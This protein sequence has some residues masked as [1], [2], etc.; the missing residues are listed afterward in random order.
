[1]YESR[2]GAGKLFAA[3]AAQ[4]P[5][6]QREGEAAIA[7]ALAVLACLLAAACVT[8]EVAP[9]D[10]VGDLAPTGTLRAA[11]GDDGVSAAL[12]RELAKRLGVPVKLVTPREASDVAFLR[13]ERQGGREA[14]FV[15]ATPPG[16]PLGERYLREFLDEMKA[17]GFIAAQSEKNRKR[18]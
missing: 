9:P 12:A 8:P 6:G 4:V 15:G 18:R 3:H 5:P 11:V 10:V 7:R 2:A 14:D 13:R 17:S 16:H 1:M